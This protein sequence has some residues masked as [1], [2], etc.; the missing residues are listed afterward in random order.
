MVAGA[1]AGIG[2]NGGRG[3][4]ANSDIDGWTV[5]SWM[6]SGRDG[7]SGESCGTVNI[8]DSITIYAYGGDG[9]SAIPGTNANGGTGGSGYPAAGIGGGGAGGGG[10]DHASGGGGY[11]GGCGQPY[12]GYGYNGYSSNQTSFTFGTGGA[13]FE[14]GTC[15]ETYASKY[16]NPTTLH[17]IGGEGG[18]ASPSQ[19]TSG[20]HGGIAGSGGTIL[21]S[22]DANIFAFNGNR[23]TDGESGHESPRQEGNESNQCPIYGQ[24][25]IFRDVYVY[26]YGIASW[27]TELYTDMKNFAIKNFS[28]YSIS[29][30]KS[31]TSDTHTNLLVRSAYSES[32]LSYS[33]PTTNNAYGIGTGAGYVEVSNGTFEPISE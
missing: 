5:G 24:A 17:H 19:T 16:T 18:T 32:P 1:G 31:S 14:N 2:G 33:N 25:G 4:N 8:K 13:Y 11:S 6:S 30:A 28:A 7:G 15:S 3:G 27:D 26:D 29:S 12:L 22:S 23:Y 10:G 21:Y 20:G 9:A